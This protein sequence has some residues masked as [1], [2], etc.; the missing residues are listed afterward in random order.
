MK[1]FPF[2]IQNNRIR[3]L[4]FRAIAYNHT[5]SGFTEGYHKSE[6]LIFPSHRC[7]DNYRYKHHTETDDN[8]S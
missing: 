4:T 3:I 7:C 8:S 6:K 2:L 5:E 1:K